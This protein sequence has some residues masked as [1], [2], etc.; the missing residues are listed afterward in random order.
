MRAGIIA[1]AHCATPPLIPQ[2]RATVGSATNASTY[3][4]SDIPIGAESPS[5][6]VVIVITK[7]GYAQHSITGV[8]VGGVSASI[9][10]S[11]I[12][13]GTGGSVFVARAVVPSGT[14]ADVVVTGSSSLS[15][16]VGVWTVDAILQVASTLV[17]ARYDYGVS[18]VIDVPANGF[19]V[20]GI[21]CRATPED[22]LD[23]DDFTLRGDS[24]VHGTD[25]GAHLFGDSVRQG[26][27]S[28]SYIASSTNRTY[29][30][31]LSVAYTAA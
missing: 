27:N 3:T 2:H 11:A 28:V 8:T 9:D 5:R 17:Y 29:N 18:V 6:S 26:L 16:A 22:G 23:I 10:A 19:A 31:G 24:Y 20:L 4:F 13:G 25:N 14:T 15:L 7:S 1:S 12:T 21:S 30:A